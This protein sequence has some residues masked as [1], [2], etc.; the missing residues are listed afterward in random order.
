ME[1]YS[2]GPPA[3]AQIKTGG[4]KF[5]LHHCMSWRIHSEQCRSELLNAIRCGE[6]SLEAQ[7]DLP[8]PFEGPCS[9]QS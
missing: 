1:F 2:S 3:Q 4:K 6:V 8:A 9:A 7:V 5:R